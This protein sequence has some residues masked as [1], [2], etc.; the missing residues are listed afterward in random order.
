MNDQHHA[1]PKLVIFDTTL[2][3]GE[4]SPGAA[5]TAAEKMEIAAGLERLGVD[6]IEAGFPAS[7]PGDLAAVKAIAGRVKD[8]AVCGLARAS[9][10][11][12]DKA[13]EAVR[14]AA[15][16]RVHTFIA[17]SPLHMAK[18]LRL[19]PEEVLARAAAAVKRARNGVADV[20]FSPEDAGRSE[21]D[22]LC[23]IIEAA[24]DAG[25]STIN[26]PDTVGYRLP[27]EFA[28]L[29]RDMMERVPNADKAVFSVH[30]HDD[31]GMAV[32]NSLAAVQA[33][34]RQVECTVNGIGERAGNAALEELVM[35]VRTRGDAFPCRV[36]VD[37]TRIL[38]LSR[39][40]AATTGMAVQRNKAV[41]GVNAFAHE[42]G[43]HQDGV[44]KDRATYEIMRAE[45]VGWDSNSLPLG[46]LSGRS[47]VRQRLAALGHELDDGAMD[48]FFALFKE[49]A[50]AQRFIYDEDL[51]ALR[52]ELG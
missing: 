38:A 50:D 44:L 29:V 47:A 25:A 6:V 4:Q 34:A 5:M 27:A 24:I 23:R 19:P 48:R 21:P 42:S 51:R 32:A 12:V 20:E 39:L 1:K 37:A 31:L 52:T 2:R 40:V 46:K 33:G 3:D 45:D 8:S 16:P 36:E 35:A 30:C 17:S 14:G 43:I 15:R 11:D 22:F 28:A 49:R 9:A 18:K 41:V 10:A 7:S 26:I 13:V